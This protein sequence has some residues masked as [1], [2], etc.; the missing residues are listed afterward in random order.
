MEKVEAV[1]FD[2]GNVIC[3]L[4]NGLFIKRISRY[5]EL[6]EAELDRLIYQSSDLPARYETGLITSDEFFVAVSSLCGLTVSRD[7][8]VEAYTDIFTPIDTSFAL[9]KRLSGSLKLGLLS[10][11]SEWDYQYGIKTTGLLPYFDSVSLSFKCRSMKPDTGIYHHA[12]RELAVNPSFCVYIDDKDEY[13]QV[14]NDLGMFGICYRQE[15]GLLSEL[16][17]LGID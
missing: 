8:F 15:E 6:D 12:L 5:S 3:R 2:F 7:V 17:K 4:D 11:T 10:N 14:A 9:I 1:I 13:V 16:S